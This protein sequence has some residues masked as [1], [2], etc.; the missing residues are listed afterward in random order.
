[1]KTGIN[2]I[3]I[4]LVFWIVF[5]LSIFT[6]L[7]Y[8]ITVAVLLL[9]PLNLIFFLLR[10][11]IKRKVNR[12]YAAWTVGSCLALISI[13]MDP[14]PKGAYFRPFNS[15][16]WKA[17]DTWR[18]KTPTIRRQMLGSLYWLASKNWKE[19]D[20]IKNLGESA[21]YFQSLAKDGTAKKVYSYRIDNEDGF[22]SIDSQWLVFLLNENGEIQAKKIMGD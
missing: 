16:K 11:A 2:A 6:F 4:S 5:Q 7:D 17:E 9:T 1:M 19:A 18:K 15:E 14:L 22:I 21:E 8:P 3:V 12:K 10:L 13:N 20:L